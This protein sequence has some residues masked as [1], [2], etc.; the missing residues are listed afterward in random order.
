MIQSFGLAILLAEKHKTPKNRTCPI[1]IQAE[2][3][4]PNCAHK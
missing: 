2:K 4:I 1:F 3:K